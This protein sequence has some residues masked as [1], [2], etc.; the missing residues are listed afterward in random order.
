VLRPA[1]PPPEFDLELAVAS[2]ERIRGLSPAS[3]LL[4]HYGHVG[5][6]DH[7]A[8][9]DAACDEAVAG[10]HRWAGWVGR[11][12]GETADLDEAAALVERSA[13]AGIEG[14]LEAGQ[15]ARLEKT[16]SY[17]MNTWGYMRYLD[18]REHAAVSG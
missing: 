8:S 16:T 18:R 4:A 12:R 6:G 7:G 5:S 3:L 17:R 10:L 9:A 14:G 2:I 15:V 11:A 13:R 1:T